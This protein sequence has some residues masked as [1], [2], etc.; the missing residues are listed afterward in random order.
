MLHTHRHTHRNTN[1]HSDPPIVALT[2]PP[3]PL[4]PKTHPT[5]L[6]KLFTERLGHSGQLCGCCVVVECECVTTMV[7]GLFAL[8]VCLFFIFGTTFPEFSSNTHF[9]PS[10]RSPSHLIIHTV[11]YSLQTKTT[12]CPPPSPKTLTHIR[13]YNVTRVKIPDI[14]T[15]TRTDSHHYA[16]RPM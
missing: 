15:Q 3:P 16:T 8:V 5:K 6:H 9:G 7:C 13:L 4:P 12:L 2:S 11:Q 1:Q 10:P 14:Y